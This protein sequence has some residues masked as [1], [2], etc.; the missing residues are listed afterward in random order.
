[1]LPIPPV[2]VANRC[3]PCECWP[4]TTPRSLFLFLKCALPFLAPR[5]THR[6]FLQQQ[7]SSLSNPYCESHPK[8]MFPG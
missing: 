4:Q 2:E 8:L 7:C 3:K 6:S 5:A 1:M